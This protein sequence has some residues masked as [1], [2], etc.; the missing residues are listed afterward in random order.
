VSNMVTKHLR[1]WLRAGM[2]G[3]DFAKR[4]SGKA[5]RIA[6]ELYPN[7][8]SPPTEIL[9]DLFDAHGDEGRAVIA[10]FPQLTSEASLADF[11]N[12]FDRDRWRI[13]RRKKSSPNGSTLVGIEWTTKEGDRSDA[14]GFA[15]FPSMPVSRRAPYTAIATWPGVRSNPF[16]GKGST[17]PARAGVVSFL[18]APPDLDEDL[19]EKHWQETTARVS[20]LMTMPPDD[21][22]L[23]R[24]AAFVI[25][26][27]AATGLLF[28]D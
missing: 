14:M 25:S 21:S 17:P 2:T 3:C 7:T 18:D 8:T 27:E 6:I 15:P 16:R 26:P 13:R 28:D 11:L 9:N 20:G 12:A 22:K 5:D 10:V 4:L 19:Y 1:L 24:N 23:Y